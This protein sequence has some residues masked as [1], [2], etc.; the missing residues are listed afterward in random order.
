MALLEVLVNVDKTEL[1][2]RMYIMTLR[3]SDD[4][5]IFT[6]PDKELPKEWWQPGN[7]FLK[8]WGDRIFKENKFMAIK[9]RSAVLQSSYNYI[10]NPQHPLFYKLVNVIKVQ[11]L[12][13][14][15][16]LM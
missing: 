8:E 12:D 10:L 13:T 1:P 4:S 14:D 11:K 7:I 16:R 9:A 5:P 3:I 2:P 15:T 6:V